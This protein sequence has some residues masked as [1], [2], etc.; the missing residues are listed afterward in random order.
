MG[1]YDLGLGILD[2]GFARE[3]FGKSE[4]LKVKTENVIFSL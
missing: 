1:H 2:R 4:N 3:T